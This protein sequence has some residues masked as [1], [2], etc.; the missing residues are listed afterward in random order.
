MRKETDQKKNLSNKGQE[1]PKFDG[2]HNLSKKFK[3][4]NRNTLRYIPKHILIILNESNRE[5]KILESKKR[6]KHIM[7]RES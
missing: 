3:E 2:K 4:C 7:I 1:L 5:R 6:N